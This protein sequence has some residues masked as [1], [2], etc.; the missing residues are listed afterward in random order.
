VVSI[1]FSAA[2]L[3]KAL[4]MAKSIS[5]PAARQEAKL[6]IR[7]LQLSDAHLLQDKNDCFIG[8]N[9]FLSLQHI[10]DDAQQFAPYDCILST[11]DLAQEPCTQSYQDYLDAVAPLN[12]YHAFIRGNH[13]TGPSFPHNDETGHADVQVI[14]IDGWC[15]ILLNSQTDAGSF[16]QLSQST[17]TELQLQLEQ[18]RHQHIL[19][20]IHHHSLPIGCAWLD[21]QNLINAADFISCIRACPQIKVVINGHVHQACEAQLAHIRLMSCPSTCV[22]FTPNSHNF[23]LDQHPPGY[24][25]LELYENGS[26]HTHIHYL[27]ACFGQI[28][29]KL[30]HY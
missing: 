11:G 13:D 2:Q 28:D 7:I 20:A 21:Q 9:P 25:I 30:T 23:S 3:S 5:R 1:I 17:L 4:S 10:I 27:A 19:L 18:H 16:G 8:V 12:S 6:P 26:I 24:R 15:C 29:K 14:N 22:Q